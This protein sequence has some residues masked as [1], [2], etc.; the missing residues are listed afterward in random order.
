MKIRTWPRRPSA[1]T[2][3][4]L[5]AAAG[6]IGGAAVIAPQ[7]AAS[8][9][10]TRIHQVDSATTT[11]GTVSAPGPTATIYAYPG[12]G[13]TLD[14]S[15]PTA[16]TLADGTQVSIQC[17]LTGTTPV[18]GPD[19]QASDL[20][21]DQ[22]DT[23]ASGL[24]TQMPAAGD[25][26]VV[27]DAL[28]QTTTPV[29]QIAPPCPANSGATPLPTTTAAPSSTPAPGSTSGAPDPVPPPSSFQCQVDLRAN[30]ALP[31]TPARHM[32]VIYTDA[33]GRQSVFRG[34]PA[35]PPPTTNYGSIVAVDRPY[36][37]GAVDWSTTDPSQ[38]VASGASACGL[39][40]CF[41]S[42]VDRINSLQIPYQ[43]LGPN[44][45]SVAYTILSNCGLP[46]PSQPPFGWAP[47]W[48][49]LI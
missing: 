34:G 5:L 11:L 13:A 17:Y 48:G 25:V 6:L 46:Q 20:Y 9:P 40:V 1:R 10:A 29:T 32:Y 24:T 28:I 42:Q 37:P 2:G 19:G 26:A 41:S 14:T 30:Y 15:L 12:A 47:G 27:P 38:I 18:T 22:I 39:A 35:N 33:I 4:A 7:L 36:G 23:A 21:W 44:S 8:H 43:P 45:N 31:P 49:T 16:G 3:I